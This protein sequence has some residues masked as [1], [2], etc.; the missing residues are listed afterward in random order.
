MLW[1]CLGRGSSRAGTSHRGFVLS[2][3]QGIGKGCDTGD[4]TRT[5]KLLVQCSA[6]PDSWKL[7]ICGHICLSCQLVVCVTSSDLN[8]SVTGL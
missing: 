5:D 2:R 3:A 7:C 6:L 1:N 8:H 4:P